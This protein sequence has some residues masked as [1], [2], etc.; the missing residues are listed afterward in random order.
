MLLVRQQKNLFSG[1]LPG[2]GR[3]DLLAGKLSSN[4]SIMVDC[5]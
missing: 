5:G 3:R 1:D 4:P 2:A